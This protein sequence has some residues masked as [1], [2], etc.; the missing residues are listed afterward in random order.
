MEAL[1]NYIFVAAADC[2]GHGVPGA[3]VSVVCSNALTKGVLEE[4]IINTD[5]ILNK[6]REIIIEK[7]T[8]E[9]NI[10]DGMDICLVRLTKD[11]NEIQYSG[12]NRPL[13]V[14]QDG[15]L[16]EFKPDKQ[17]IGRYEEIQSFTKQDIILQKNSMLYLTTDGYADQFGGEKGKKIGTKA[18]KEILVKISEVSETEKQ[19]VEMIKYFQQ[20]KGDE[21]QMDDVTVIG[22]RV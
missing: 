2:T 15:V 21:E 9:E 10:R 17:P 14:V 12:A 3:M 5:E 22:I 1:D 18:F 8:S 6:V 20:W 16:T 19:R 11:S 7:L 13:Y 4:K